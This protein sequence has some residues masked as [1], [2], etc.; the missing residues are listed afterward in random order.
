MRYPNLINAGLIVYSQLPVLTCNDSNWKAILHKGKWTLD[1]T[2]ELASFGPTLFC[3]VASFFFPM[4]LRIE[5]VCIA[6]GCVMRS[7]APGTPVIM[8][9]SQLNAPSELMRIEY[10]G[11]LMRVSGAEWPQWAPTPSTYA[12]QWVDV[13]ALWGPMA[14][15]VVLQIGATGYTPFSG[16]APMWTVSDILLADGVLP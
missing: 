13:S 6:A 1:I 2:G 12:G 15:L 16:A 14:G 8:L 5:I 9:N 7:N 3:E 11:G 4:A 10:N